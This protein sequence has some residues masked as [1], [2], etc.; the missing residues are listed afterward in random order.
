[1]RNG[2]GWIALIVCAALGG[3]LCAQ[4][5]TIVKGTVVDAAGKPVAG[6]D[7]AN[8]WIAGEGAVKSL[9]GFGGAPSM[10]PFG[11]AKS[12]GAGQFAVKV[13]FYGRPQAV[14]ALDKERNRGGVAVVEAAK[15]TSPVTIKLAP[16]VTVQGKFACPD[17]DRRPPWTNVYMSLL[18]GGI[19]VVQCSSN[20]ASFAFKLPPGK[21]QFWGYGSDVEGIVKELELKA[22]APMLDLKTIDLPGSIIAKHVGKAPPVWNVTDARGVNKNVGLADFKGKWVLIEF[23]GFW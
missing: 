17:L 4:E 1:M 3:S 9:L 21:Y 20:N 7:V 18:P 10:T 2:V 6:A 5:G 11:N 15:A 8:F 16:L 22:A 12:D 13:D 19:R 14:M 23:W